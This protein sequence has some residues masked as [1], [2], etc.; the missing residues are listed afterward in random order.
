M[1]ATRGIL[2]FG[3]GVFALYKGWLIHTG[4]RAWLAYILGLVAIALGIW[5][6]LRRPDKPPV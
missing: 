2:L 6:L 1:N 5:R 3:L 4:Q